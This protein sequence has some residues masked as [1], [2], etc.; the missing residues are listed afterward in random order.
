[1]YVVDT[2]FAAS[3]QLVPDQKKSGF[4]KT[5]NP[6]LL[7]FVNVSSS[8]MILNKELIARILAKKDLI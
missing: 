6:V 2:S 7:F 5:G 1:M 4:L 3:I 8:S